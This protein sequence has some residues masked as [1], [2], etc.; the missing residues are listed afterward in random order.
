MRIDQMMYLAWKVLVPLTIGL[1]VVQAIVQK[2]P[3]PVAVQYVLIF[4]ANIGVLAIVI[5]V[6]NGY[7]RDE[8]IRTKRSF[9]PASLIGTMQASE[10]GTMY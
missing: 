10:D 9:E 3:T 8:Q 4:I 6:L 5:K 7:F 1:I 2:L